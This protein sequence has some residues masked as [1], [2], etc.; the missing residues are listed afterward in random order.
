MRPT[1]SEEKPSEN[2]IFA[3]PLH[4]F[5]FPRGFV[6]YA[7]ILTV[8]EAVVTRHWMPAATVVMVHW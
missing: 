5:M 6:Q 2:V 3:R 7:R 4:I 8:P 1:V